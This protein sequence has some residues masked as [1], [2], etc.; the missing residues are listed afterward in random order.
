MSINRTMK[1]L[2]LARL[3]ELGYCACFYQSYHEG[4][5][6]TKRK[7]KYLKTAIN[8]TMKELKHIKSIW[9]KREWWI[10]QSYHEG[11]ETRFCFGLLAL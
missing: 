2:K 10:Y 5:E 11:I 9:S 7:G 1:E 4:I 3:Q 8:R 6:T